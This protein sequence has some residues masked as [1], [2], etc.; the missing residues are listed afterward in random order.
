MI[1]RKIQA[2]L[3]AGA[4]T[5]LTAGSTALAYPQDGQQDYGIR[6]LEGY[7]L[8]QRAPTGRKLARVS[9]GAPNANAW[10]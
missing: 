9:C 5:A 1:T 6:R 10:D 7:R 2:W 8:A 4:L 3:R